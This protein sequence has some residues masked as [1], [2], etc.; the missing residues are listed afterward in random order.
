MQKQAPSIGRILVAAGFALSCFG[1]ILFL[2]I[3]FGGPIPLK[4]ESYRITAYFPEATQLAQ[5]SDVRIGGVSV[6]KVK[7]IELAP[8]SARVNGKDTTKAEIEIDPEFAPI[9][10]DARAILRQKTLLGETYVELTSGTE[11]GEDSAPVSLGAAANVSDAE[12]EGIESIE[13]GGTLGVGQTEEATQIDEIFNALDEETRTSFQRW[14][15]NAALA[16]QGRGL[17]LNDSLGN[18]GPF[19]T[20]ASNVV[21]ILNRQKQ[22]LKGLV[23]DTG[24]VFEALTAQDQALAGAI[25]GSEN[26]FEALARE[27]RA[28]AESFQIFPTFER[29]SRLTFERLD[30]FQADTHPLVRDL[31]PVARDLSPTLR[32]VRRLSPDLRKLFV[33]LGKLETASEDGLPA[34]ERTLDGL[35]PVFDA[36]DPFLA[37]LNP[38]LRYLEFQKLTMTDFMAGPGV[39]LSGALDKFS[40]D[41]APRHYL[42]QIGYLGAES[43]SLHPNRLPTNRGN[44]YN[45]PGALNSPLAVERGMYASFD[46]KNPD[47][48]PLAGGDNDEDIILSGQ[49]LPD[50]HG[51]QPPDAH[52]AP[53]WIAGDFPASPFGSF[54]DGR[55]PNVF[56]DP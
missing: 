34:L 51:G 11:P 7:T 13:E 53:C 35:A 40:G 42:R 37:N 55:A 54:G 2:W 44:G 19:I 22:A 47:Y 41:P 31:I 39:A 26:T 28:L 30:E 10:E 49:T 48:A 9:S 25:I 18:L 43:L 52:F 56:P 50:V 20:D 5:E 38:A 29:E 17:D 27:E 46:C 33:K 14:Q 12:A 15:Q 3:A 21:E 16:I 4:P 24:T 1:L 45:A 23:R 32:S 6:G 36:L 8:E